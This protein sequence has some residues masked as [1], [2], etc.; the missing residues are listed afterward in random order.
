MESEF[1]TLDKAGKEAEWLQ[2]FLEDIPMWPKPVT[3]MCIHCD[4]QETLSRAKNAVYNGKSRQIR[5]RHNTIK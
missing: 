5:C 3:A 4:S 1:T 2:N